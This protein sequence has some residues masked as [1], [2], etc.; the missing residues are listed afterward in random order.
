MSQKNASNTKKK[1]LTRSCTENSI[2]CGVSSSNPFGSILTPFREEN[3][4]EISKKMS[5]DQ[6]MNLSNNQINSHSSIEEQARKENR[7]ST[8]QR[9][10]LDFLLARSTMPESKKLPRNWK[11]L[12]VMYPNIC[13]VGTV[14]SYFNASKYYDHWIRIQNENPELHNPVETLTNIQYLNLSQDKQPSQDISRR[15]YPNLINGF[16]NNPE[17]IN[18]KSK[19]KTYALFTNETSR[20]DLGFFSA[21]NKSQKNSKKLFS[22]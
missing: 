8:K 11:Q 15:N 19:T 18:S 16:K 14:L 4:I 17:Q 22:N 6:E 20:V 12:N 7:H 10:T 9:Y 1:T 13:F 2:G 5:N 21:Q 3:S